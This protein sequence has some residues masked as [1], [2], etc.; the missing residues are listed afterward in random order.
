MVL[1][2]TKTGSKG[3]Y[4]EMD[5]TELL[6]EQ[7]LFISHTKLENVVFRSDHASNYL[8]LKGILSRD[9]EKLLNQLRNALYDPGKASLREE[10]QRGL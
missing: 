9:K 6:E 1:I 2:I 3:S 5:I 7:L 8:T 10:W 4:H